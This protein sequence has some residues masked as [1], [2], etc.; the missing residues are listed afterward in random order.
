MMTSV[1]IE[2]ARGTRDKALPTTT[3]TTQPQKQLQVSKQQHTETYAMLGII[4][5]HVFLY[6]HNLLGA[7]YQNAVGLTWPSSLFNNTLFTLFIQ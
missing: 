4:C 3:Q 2:R 7:V 5:T 1:G 6:N